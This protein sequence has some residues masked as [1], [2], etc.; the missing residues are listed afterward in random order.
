MNRAD[1]LEQSI[2]K[3][4]EYAR[5]GSKPG[6]ERVREL[7]R[8]LG[9]PHKDLKVIHV[10]GTN[11]KGSVCR[12]V[13]SVLQRAGY[14]C[15]LY[16]SPFIEEF[17]ERI[18]FD[19]EQISPEDLA[20][21]TDKVTAAAEEIVSEGLESPTEFEIITA[22]AFLYYRDKNADAVIL[23]VG[24]GGRGDA[25]NVIERP[26]AVCIASVS[27]DHM[28]YLGDTIEQIAWEKSGI[29]KTGVPLVY[30]SED[31]AV[32]RV[33]EER[34]EERKTPVYHMSKDRVRILEDRPEGI[35]FDARTYSSRYES[36]TTGMPG[37]HQVMNAL[38]AL[39]I[40][41]LLQEN[42]GFRIPPEALK[43]GISEAK[44]PGRIEILK[45]DPYV[46]LDGSHNADSVAALCSWIRA[47]FSP[48]DRL[49]VVTGV[50]KDKEY[51]KIAAMLTNVASDFIVTEPASYRKLPAEEYLW[52]IRNHLG[53]E[54]R[55]EVCANPREAAVQAYRILTEK[56][57]VNLP[58][59]GL[60][61]TGSLYM[62][63][64]VR[65]TLRTYI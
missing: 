21:L 52:V 20:V 35:V 37:E 29:L 39:Q 31:P 36:L 33:L 3:I 64:E 50:L 45:E 12:Y 30:A 55:A 49:L 17:T 5:Y 42:N 14:R 32:R 62:I 19:G 47:H 11:G 56:N 57:N 2:L 38:C 8:R 58:I 63:G 25:T 4:K 1:L 61:F 15:G 51:E 41:E 6:L 22:I 54:G 40:L 48:E 23:E 7:L 10:G 28:D 34:A 53:P 13:Y 16:I 18:E 9:D 60:I 43:T 46:V 27:M 44:Q 65:K 24:L 59:K 26:M